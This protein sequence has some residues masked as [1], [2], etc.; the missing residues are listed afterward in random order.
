MAH[1]V[2]VADTSVDGRW[3]ERVLKYVNG[4]RECVTPTREPTGVSVATCVLDIEGEGAMPH[5]VLAGML[6]VEYL[7]EYGS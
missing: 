5:L 7:F 1:G 2:T 6:L 3:R 4:P